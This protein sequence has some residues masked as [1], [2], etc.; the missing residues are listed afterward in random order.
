MFTTSLK[1]FLLTVDHLEV[2]V[3]KTPLFVLTVQPKD[4][5][6][7]LD[8]QGVKVITLQELEV[9]THREVPQLE[10]VV[11]PVEAVL[12]EAEARLRVA[13]LKEEGKL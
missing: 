2:L 9:I 11:H 10:E 13:H 8:P 1:T 6:I 12:Q 3:E 4:R 5:A 7:K